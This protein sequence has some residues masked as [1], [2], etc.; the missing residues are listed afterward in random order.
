MK[1]LWFRQHQAGMLETTLNFN[2]S[3]EVSSAGAQTFSNIFTNKKKNH[4]GL[5]IRASYKVDL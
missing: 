4:F 5:K 3:F 2:P 1:F